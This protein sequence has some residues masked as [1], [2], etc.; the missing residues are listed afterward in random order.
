[1]ASTTVSAEEQK[2]LWEGGESPFKSRIWQINDVVLLS[3]GRIYIFVFPY[4]LCGYPYEPR[5]VA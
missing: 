4:C 1:M 3:I 2:K 5:L